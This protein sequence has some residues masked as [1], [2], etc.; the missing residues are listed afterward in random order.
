MAN[1]F[2]E[3]ARSHFSDRLDG[4]PLSPV[5]KAISGLHLTICPM[6]IRYNQSLLA[7]REALS[8]LKD[9]PVDGEEKAA[10]KK[11]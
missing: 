3:A 2:C 6:C 11:P 10:P 7:S 1:K 9:L 8:L 4:E 5:A